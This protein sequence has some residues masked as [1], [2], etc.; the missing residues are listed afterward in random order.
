MKDQSNSKN[1]CVF[2]CVEG[3]ALPVV[4]IVD[5]ADNGGNSSSYLICA[6]AAFCASVD[7]CGTFL[8]LE[9]RVLRL[10]RIVF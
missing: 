10:M 3:S 4:A 6:D 7:F 5:D 2:T 8:L 1:K 9:L